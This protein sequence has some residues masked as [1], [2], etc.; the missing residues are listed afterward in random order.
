MKDQ[1]MYKVDGELYWQLWQHYDDN[2]ILMVFRKSVAN[3]AGAWEEVPDGGEVDGNQRP[4]L[5]HIL[6]KILHDGTVIYGD[7][8][9]VGQ[10]EEPD[11]D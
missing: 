4:T 10:G 11:V 8:T 5:V 2:G 9:K 3:P 7:P 6:K 1:K